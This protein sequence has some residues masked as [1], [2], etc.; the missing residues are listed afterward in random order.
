MPIG[1]TRAGDQYENSRDR[2]DNYLDFIDDIYDDVYYDIDGFDS[3]RMHE[4]T[5]R[6]SSFYRPNF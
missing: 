4:L 6:T 1:I 2:H 5:K 3:G